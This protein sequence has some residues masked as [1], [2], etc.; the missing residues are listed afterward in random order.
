MNFYLKSLSKSAASFV[1]FNSHQDVEISDIESTLLDELNELSFSKPWTTFLKSEIKLHAAIL[2]I[3]NGDDFAAFWSLKQ[4]YAMAERNVENHPEFF[5]SYKTLG[6]LHIL[7]GA[8]PDKYD[9]ILSILGLEDDID[10]G[11]EEL[12]ISKQSGNFLSLE[13]T[14]ITALLHAYLLND[15]GSGSTIM[16]SDYSPGQFQL[17]DYA[18]SLILMKNA[19]SEK[20][21]SVIDNLLD[22]NDESSNIA[23]LYYNKAEILLQKGQPN[24]ATDFYKRFL[25]LHPNG[26][27]VKD[28]YYK[29]GICFLIQGLNDSTHLYFQKAEINGIAK[30]EA[31]R[32][33]SQEIENED[34]P[35]KQLVQL[36]YATDGGFYNVAF[37]IYS[38]INPESLNAHDKCEFWYRSARLSHKTGDLERAL[39]FY[40]KSIS[41]QKVKDWYY[42]PNSALQSALIYIAKN[43]KDKA[44]EYLKMVDNYSGYPYQNSIRQ[45]KR[46]ALKKIN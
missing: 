40:E 17:L 45:K 29:I 6:L 44:K 35:N 24:Q 46:A 30:N 22:R 23:Q 9:W 32:N 1:N 28:S 11:L 36:R 7:Y 43:E 14:T 25:I 39:L 42:G 10:K 27:L 5:P 18:L 20:A 33:A 3:K 4:A 31:D 26:N 37:N 21:L 38:E 34:L 16:Q 2:K 15:P 8:F 13:I 19:E 12:E 41:A